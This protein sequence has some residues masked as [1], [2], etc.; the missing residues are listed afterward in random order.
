MSSDEP[1]IRHVSDT[2][3]WVASYRALESERPDALFRDP[4]AGRLTG[5]RGWEIAESIA[6]KSRYGMWSVVVRTVVIDELIQKLV[7]EGVDT[8]INLGAG[9]DTRPY[10]LHLPESLRWVEIDFPD[11][12]KLKDEVLADVVPSVA[13]KRIALD[14]AQEDVRRTL[15]GRIAASSNKC[16]VLTEGV[17]PYLTEEQVASLADDLHAEMSFRYWI[18]EYYA[19]ETYRMLKARWR[20]RKLRN[21]PFRFFPADWLGLFRAHGWTARE[22]RYLFEEAVKMGRPMPL[23]WWMRVLLRINRFWSSSE[24]GKRGGYVVYENV[25]KE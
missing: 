24:P 13:L 25:G 23:P 19:P 7:S 1:K 9:L 10:R 16:L 8:V 5:A 14:L 22:F 11:I 15:F 18:G 6:P 20:R 4:L 17:I 21:A 3:H 12:I 2:A